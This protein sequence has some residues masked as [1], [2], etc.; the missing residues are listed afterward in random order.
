MLKTRSAG[1]T[2]SEGRRR[3]IISRDMPEENPMLI[4]HIRRRL[5]L[6]LLLANAVFWVWFWAYFF[7]HAN[8]AASRPVTWESAPPW[9]VVFGR[10]FG[11]STSMTDILQVPSIR[12]ATAAYLPCF[13]LTWPNSRWAPSDFYVAGADAQGLRLLAITALSFFQW[14][15]LLR[16]CFAI[17]RVSD[18]R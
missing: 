3:N 16:L 9:A 6:L 1:L 2:H 12:I 15:I 5:T 18:R 11:N 13:L 17:R 8:D 7:V 4:W 10:G 14:I